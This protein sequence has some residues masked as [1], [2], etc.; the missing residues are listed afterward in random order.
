MLYV[1]HVCVCVCICV[2]IVACGTTFGIPQ[3]ATANCVRCSPFC[4]RSIRHRNLS[5]PNDLGMR[6]ERG[7]S[8]SH[9]KYLEI[10]KV[11]IS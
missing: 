11:L 3:I 7:E 9:W 5:A 1:T 8:K 10:I 2:F 4:L 6:G